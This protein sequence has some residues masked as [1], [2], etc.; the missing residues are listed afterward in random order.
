MERKVALISCRRHLKIKAKVSPLPQGGPPLNRITRTLAVLGVLAFAVTPPA[1]SGEK[2]SIGRIIIVGN[3]ETPDW[4][5]HEFLCL[6]SGNRFRYPEIRIAERDLAR[7][8]RFVVD[9][10]NNIRPTIR[11]LKENDD[12]VDLV[13]TVHERPRSRYVPAGFDAV[14]LRSVGQYYRCRYLASDLV[15]VF[16]EALANWGDSER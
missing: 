12:V 7:C 3:A 16:K 4:F 9:P 13:I 5:V 14:M 15:E 2:P 8:G 6:R 11:I 10:Q 1:L